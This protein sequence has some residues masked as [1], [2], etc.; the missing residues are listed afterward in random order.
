MRVAFY[1]P[2]KQ[3]DH[4][5][6]SG[7]RR[8]AQALYGLV[9]AAGHEAEIACR[10][11]SYDRSGDGQRQ[12]RLAA[13]GA[14]LADRLASR[15]AGRPPDR[16]PDAWL[17]Y[18]VY[19]KAP[20]YLGPR[21]IRSLDL[22][23]LVVE[24]SRAASQA[25]GP[26]ATGYAASL[27]SFACA[28][29]V[30]AMTEN[31][32]EGLTA[33]VRPPARLVVFPPFLDTAPFERA[34]E[35]RAAQRAAVAARLAL[36]ARQPW[37]LT[38]AMMRDDVKRR[39]YG[40]LADALARLG[41]LAWQLIVVGDGPAR[42]AVVERLTRAAAGRVHA[43]GALPPEALP[44]ICAA[45]DLY[46]WPALREASGMAILEAQA[47]GLP[48]VVGAEGG[49]PEIVRDGVTGLLCDG[50]DPADVARAVRTL[51]EDPTRRRAM[52]RAARRHVRDRHGMVAAAG[53]LD[54]ALMAARAIR[55]ERIAMS[56]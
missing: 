41:D 10:L 24:A 35:R 37:L 53:R 19:H 50:S 5:A 55:N 17:T 22:P 29:V 9:S 21:V 36:D 52:G 27:E 47:G 46:V 8:M 14:R 4:P 7:D 15:L 44:E 31:D 11:R 49:V 26:W 6:P 54:E 43:T 32:R 16:R 30:L 51:L 18:H 45:S 12:R 13:L 23:Y 20:D 33:I 42:D 1:A 56:G 28:D 48:V 25:G 3:L 34:R 38:I 39:S 2:L 40:V